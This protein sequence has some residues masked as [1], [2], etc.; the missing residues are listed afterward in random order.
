MAEI[1]Q[2]MQKKVY[3]RLIVEPQSISEHNC[4]E[5]LVEIILFSYDEANFKSMVAVWKLWF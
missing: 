3:W 4:K 2:F 1:F 5:T